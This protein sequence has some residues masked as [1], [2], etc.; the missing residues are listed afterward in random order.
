M[1]QRHLDFQPATEG[2]SSAAS[3]TTPSSRDGRVWD[4]C[5]PLASEGTWL[6][7][8]SAGTGK[9]WQLASLVA[10]LVIEQEPP[11]PI[12]KLLIITFTNAATAELRDRVRKRLVE[13]RDHLTLLTRDPASVP[14]VT[15]PIAQGDDGRDHVLRHL[16]VGPASGP[17]LSVAEQTNRLTRTNIA[18]ANFDLA[19]ISTIHGFCQ[20]M[21]DSLAFESGQDAG[22]SLVEDITP[23]R[24]DLVADAIATVQATASPDRWETYQKQWRWQTKPLADVV[25]KACAVS[26]KWIAPAVDEAQVQETLT[27]LDQAKAELR[28]VVAKNQPESP[29]AAYETALI[30]D[31]QARPLAYKVS[32]SDAKLTDDVTTVSTWA[33]DGADADGALTALKKLAEARTRGLRSKAPTAPFVSANCAALDGVLAQIANDRANAQSPEQ[34]LACDRAL[35][36]SFVTGVGQAVA[37]ELARDA[38]QRPAHYKTT[39]GPTYWQ[40]QQTAIAQWPG[41]RKMTAALHKSAAQFGAEGRKKALVAKSTPVPLADQT[42]VTEQVLTLLGKIDS[43]QASVNPLAAFAVASRAAMASELERRRAMTFDSMLTKLAE[44]I[45]RE[46]DCGGSRPLR[47]AIRSQFEVALIDEF[48]DTDVAQWTVLR[49]VFHRAAG[50]RLFLIGD[51]KQAIYR[52]RGADVYVYLGAKKLLTRRDRS[53]AGQFTMARNYRSDGPLVAALNALWGQETKAFGDL[54][55]DYVQVDWPKKQTKSCLRAAPAL[56]RPTGEVTPRQPLEIRWLD[57]GSDANGERVLLSTKADGLTEAAACCAEE[58]GQ[59]LA[60]PTRLVPRPTGTESADGDQES[61]QA[62]SRLRPGDIAVLVHEHKHGRLVKLALAKRGI[63]AVT[64]GKN[65]VFDSPVAMWML[66]LLDALAQPAFEARSRALAVSPLFGFSLAQLARALDAADAGDHGDG[67]DEAHNREGQATAEAHDTFSKPAANG[68]PSAPGPAEGR[69]DKPLQWD[70]W[71]QQIEAWAER[72]TKHRFA[73]VIQRMSR[74]YEL[75]GQLLGLQDG[76]RLATDFR[77]LFELCHVAEQQHHFGPAGL[78]DWLRKERGKGQK[79]GNNAASPR[80]E[81]DAKAVQIVT[82]YTAKGLQ[83]PVVMLP[84]AWAVNSGPK[85]YAPVVIHPAGETAGDAT[86][87]TESAQPA[88]GHAVLSIHRDKSAAHTAAKERDKEEELE[89][90]LRKLYVE[91]TR[92]EHHCVLW[93]GAVGPDFHRSAA[94]ALILRPDDHVGLAYDT[95]EEQWGDLGKK[96]TARSKDPEAIAQRR[97]AANRQVAQLL[98]QRFDGQSG[99]GWRYDSRPDGPPARYKPEAAV[100]VPLQPG[101]YLGRHRLASAWQ[102]ASFSSMAPSMGTAAGGTG[103]ERPQLKDDVLRGGMDEAGPDDATPDGHTRT[104]EA[105]RPT[106]GSPAGAHHALP[107]ADMWG[108]TKVGTWAH[109][110]LE[111][112]DF[113]PKDCNGAPVEITR[114]HLWP[115]VDDDAARS[116]AAQQSPFVRRG[117][118]GQH[119]SAM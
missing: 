29:W 76:E 36:A 56:V 33:R 30:A 112:L 52:F 88:H 111:L 16:C 92:A 42:G 27:A 2:H 4:P 85:G 51:P 24:D 113:Q 14:E 6:L 58:I 64:A 12:E 118:A 35:A 84:F 3:G 66:Q 103:A 44:S 37:A 105:A 45:E 114:A 75:V 38:S 18:L 63:M 60:S 90:R 101:A 41:T 19:P 107:L 7:E 89:E 43:L 57:G 25:D 91:M 54:E 23:L 104:V 86:S 110:I 15:A 95:V 74:D 68:H 55:M 79:S 48:Q 108:G 20:R 22:L 39:R 94:N 13:V 8:A 1:S 59:L 26:G 9:T 98:S 116:A 71:R 34:V 78:A 10:R 99:A 109:A 67:G 73:G 115:S 53:G 32:H 61:P 81:S 97:Y 31:A 93:V 117:D 46:R 70:A 11:V 50:R 72:W 82:T 62:G 40:A 87:E 65:T 17:N 100:G 21:L 119:Q 49:E 77:H 80:L 47:D 28:L 96:V 106:P 69:Q 83:Y 102:R 5:S